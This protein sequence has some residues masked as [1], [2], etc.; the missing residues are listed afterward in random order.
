MGHPKERKQAGK[1]YKDNP[2]FDK[3]GFRMLGQCWKL[4]VIKEPKRY[5]NIHLFST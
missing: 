5:D 4:K 1:A 2:D 3:P